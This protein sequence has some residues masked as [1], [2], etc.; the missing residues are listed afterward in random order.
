M[1]KELEDAINDMARKTSQS[2]NQDE[3]LKYSQAALNLAHTAQV[4]E[5]V[6]KLPG[7]KPA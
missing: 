2:L 6:S 7:N 4:I 3:A 1:Y 5:H